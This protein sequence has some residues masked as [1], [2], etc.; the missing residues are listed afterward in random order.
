MGMVRD[1]F[2]PNSYLSEI[3]NIRR[4]LKARTLVLNV[5]ERHSV[6][7][8]SLAGEAEIGYGVVIHHLRLLE[9][10]GIVDR[11]GGK[12]PHVWVLTGAGQKRLLNSS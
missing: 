3:K 1:T 6:D 11:K 4:G 5:L 8:R 7:A 9:A 2:H 10:E 12:K